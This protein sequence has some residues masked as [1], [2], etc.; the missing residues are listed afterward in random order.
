MKPSLSSLT[1]LFVLLLLPPGFV[2]APLPTAINPFF[3]LLSAAGKPWEFH[4]SYPG[5]WSKAQW[6]LWGK[7]PLW[8]WKHDSS[9]DHTACTGQHGERTHITEA[10]CCLKYCFFCYYK[11]SVTSVLW[12]ACLLC[13]AKTKGMDTK[14]DIGVKY[15]DKQARHFDDDKIKAGQCVIGLQ[16]IM[17]WS[18]CGS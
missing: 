12:L 7:W 8:K 18:L 13:Q 1:A 10:H 16:V 9:P 17:R 15:A 6:H 2:E 3:L 4:Q 11:A 5:L 14:I